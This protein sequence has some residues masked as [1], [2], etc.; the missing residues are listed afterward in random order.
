MTREEAINALGIVK[1]MES[2]SV[3]YE[4]GEPM[5]QTTVGELKEACRMAISILRAQTDTAPNDPLTL[6]QLR[7]MDGEPVWAEIPEHRVTEWCIAKFDPLMGR[8]R[9][10]CSGGGWFDGKNC[11]KS[12]F[13]YRRKPEEFVLSVHI[14]KRASSETIYGIYV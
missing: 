4:A 1:H 3:F 5:N 9:L 11:G 2:L 13:I 14:K 10:W 6:E 12:V 8:M 7:E